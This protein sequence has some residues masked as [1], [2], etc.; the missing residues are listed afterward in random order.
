MAIKTTKP[1]PIKSKHFAIIEISGRQERVELGEKLMVDRCK[2]AEG[3]KFDTDKVL[4]FADGEKIEVG[5]PYVSTKVTFQVL[6]N[7]RGP[8]V[9]TIK[10]KAKTRYRKKHGFKP[11]LTELLITQIGDKEMEEVKPKVK[12]AAVKKISAK[13]EKK[14]IAKKATKTKAK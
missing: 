13:S 9:T 11:L 6:R 3:E 12:K 1:K 2:Y 14:P 5:T 10:F 4:L 8:K 7:L